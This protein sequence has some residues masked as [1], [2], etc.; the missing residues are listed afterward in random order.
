[1]NLASAHALTAPRGGSGYARVCAAATKYR[2]RYLG[3]RNGAAAV[4]CEAECNAGRAILVLPNR[5]LKLTRY[6][7]RCLAAPGQVCYFP[8][9]AKQRTPPRSA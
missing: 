4:A 1:M 8:S 9:A 5:S 6:G 3:S 7:M 2:S